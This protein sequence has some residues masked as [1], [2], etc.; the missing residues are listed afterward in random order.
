[1]GTESRPKPRG[2]TVRKNKSGETIQIAFTYQG[3]QCREIVPLP[4]TR[5]NINY[6]ANLLGEIKGAIERETF[7]YAK[8]FPNSKRLKVLGQQV[9]SS[10][11]VGE[12]MFAFQQDCIKRGLSPSS[13]EG[14]RK[15][16]LAFSGLHDIPVRNLTPARLKQFAKESGNAPKTLR[17]KFSY[18]RTAIAEAVT[19]GVIQINPVD[20]VKLS[21]YIEK[22]NKLDLQD[23]HKDIQPFTP[24]E[25]DAIYAKCNQEELNIIKFVF[26]T[27][28]R[29]S[30]WSALKWADVDF[31]NEVVNIKTAIV[32][33]IEKTTKSRSGKRSIPLNEDALTALREQMPASYLLGAYVF[34]KNNKAP[35][36]FLNGELNRINPDSFRKHRWSKI[37][38]AAGVTYRYPYQMR[39]TYATKH[40]S[41]GVNLWQLANWMGHASPEMLFKHYGKFIEDYEQKQKQI[42][43]RNAQIKKLK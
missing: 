11:T 27:G 38:K 1:M 4:P 20:G 5:K 30:E 36:Q 6:A 24:N 43:T 33:G 8:Y 42:H 18:L 3:M 29:S 41:Q 10:K 19:D 37:I 14:Y 26:N 23:N 13:I 22:N 31:G 17:N 12:Y 25:I 15:L 2:V 9:Q 35:V 28:L 16:K 7:Q 34:C 32:H 39:H 40:I 21:N